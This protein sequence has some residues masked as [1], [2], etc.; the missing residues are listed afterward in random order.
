MRFM[1]NVLKY[2][3]FKQNFALPATT[4]IC[5]K[6]QCLAICIDKYQLFP[7]YKQIPS[8][9]SIKMSQKQCRFM[10][11]LCIDKIQY[12]HNVWQTK[13]FC[14]VLCFLRIVIHQT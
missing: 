14:V 9:N 7:F 12:D 5:D 13:A 3:L 6:T 4:A 11:H 2:T 10:L 1:K 8:K